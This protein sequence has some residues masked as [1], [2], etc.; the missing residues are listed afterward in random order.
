MDKHYH[1][2]KFK[3]IKLD[4]YIILI[5]LKLKI[6]YI[7]KIK[8]TLQKL[9]IIYLFKYISFKVNAALQYF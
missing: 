7:F 5:K 9:Y 3:T 6:T 4:A 8:I 2:T 1:C